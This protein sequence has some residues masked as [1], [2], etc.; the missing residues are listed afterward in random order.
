[1][2]CPNC[3][4]TYNDAEKSCP[5]CGELNPF[6][7]TNKQATPIRSQQPPVAGNRRQNKLPP[8]SDITDTGLVAAAGVSS[9]RGLEK[10]RLLI[11]DNLKWILVGLTTVL[12]LVVV[13][14]V[15]VLI[16]VSGSGNNTNI[17]S[18]NSSKPISSTTSL[19]QTPPISTMPNPSSAPPSPIVVTDMTISSTQPSSTTPTKKTAS[20]SPAPTVVQPTPSKNT[21]T[22]CG[23]SGTVTQTNKEE[24][25]S[26]CASCK[27]Q[28]KYYL[29]WEDVLARYARGGVTRLSYKEM[30]RLKAMVG[31]HICE[32]CNGTGVKVEYVER[33]QRTTCPQCKG[34]GNL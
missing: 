4:D 12:A 30:Q 24:I 28:G 20:T 13:F 17:G 34:K 31:W 32:S 9:S 25:R 16:I 33:Q 23:G 5:I 26:K 2:D 1:M 22:V 11:E 29:S 8:K 14:L 7:K 19:V 18:A 10:Y 3:R 21:C 15:S 27:G 6:L